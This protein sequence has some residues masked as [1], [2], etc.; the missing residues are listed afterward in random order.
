[1]SETT[2][3]D[4][5]DGM[6]H[7]DPL[8]REEKSG[9][10]SYVSNMTHVNSPCFRTDH[11]Q[12]VTSSVLGESLCG[13]RTLKR[14]AI[15]RMHHARRCDAAAIR[16]SESILLGLACLLARLIA[17]CIRSKSYTQTLCISRIAIE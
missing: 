6:R 14:T 8:K 9:D 13:I 16:T 2:A 15:V 10:L 4:W 12:A 11:P 1:M 7:L 3:K 17:D 5:I